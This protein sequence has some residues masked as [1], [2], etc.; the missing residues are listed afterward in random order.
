MTDAAPFDKAKA[1]AFMQQALGD[2]A[3]WTA[4]VLAAIGDR[5]GLFKDLARHGPATGP[6]LAD[7]TGLQPRYVQEWAAGMLIAGYLEYDPAEKRFSLPSEHVAV[8]AEE[9]GRVFF[10]GA[11]QM[12]IGL[13]AHLD[14]VCDAFRSG[15]GI[16]LDRYNPD[17]WEGM[18]RYT[19]SVHETRLV[20]QFIAGA[21]EVR[22]KL[23]Q[24]A[25]V[26]D[27]GCGRGRS[28]VKLAQSF[29]NSTFHG[30]DLFAPSIVVAQ[31]RA[32]AGGVAE[33]V[34]FRTLDVARDLPQGRYDVALCVDVLH[35]ATDPVA[36]LRGVRDALKP[37][38]R[39]LCIDVNCAPTLEEQGG[40]MDTM[41]YGLSLLYC[42]TT[43]L[44]HGGAGLGTM[45][46]SEPVMREL[47]ARAGFS[48]VET[49]PLRGPYSAWV[50]AP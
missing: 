7:R 20:Q 38:G 42:L 2:T 36:F 15:G 4:T 32:A 16:T 10:G 26:A 49:V 22:Q 11:H 23:E 47:C 17:V 30:Y 25:L 9:N 6:E 12:M 19:G 29:P 37:A 31:A 44:A 3:G 43:S 48:A 35:D 27:L 50:V 40:P 34:S 46:L 21:G 1:D 45:G 14:E 13:A 39:F 28:T 24:G 8:L 5:L 41:R 18:E 33:R